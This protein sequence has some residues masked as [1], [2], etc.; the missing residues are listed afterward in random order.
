MLNALKNLVVV[1]AS[2]IPALGIAYAWWGG[3]LKNPLV[4]AALA[5]VYETGVL[6]WAVLGKD[7]WKALQPGLV[8]ATADWTKVTVLNGFSDFRRRYNKHLVF[9]HRVFGSRGLRTQ[10]QGILELEQVFVELQIAPSHALQVSANPLA[11]KSLPGSQPVWEFLRRFKK[12]DATA[13]AI[14]GPPGCGK[15]TLLKHLALTFALNKQRRYR[16]RAYTPL[17]LFL[18]EHAQTIVEHSP[19]L[20]E[21]C[22]AHFSN[23]KRYPELDPPAKWFPRRLKA[24]KCLVLLDG[25]DEVSEERRQEISKWVDRQIREYPCCRFVLT[26]RPQGYLDAPLAQAHVLEVMSFTHE[27]VEDFVRHWYVA[28]KIIQSGKNDP[29]IHRDAERDADDL[30]QRLQKQKNLQELTV[31]PLLLTMIANVHNYR[32]ALP[33]RRVELYMEICDVL[34]GHWQKAKG[35]ED[36]L[37]AKQ[38]RAV[39]QPLAEDMMAE[40]VREMSTQDVL[41][42]MESHLEGV[43]LVKGDAPLFLKNLQEHSGLLLETEAELWG[44]AHLTFQ[45][46]LCAAHWHENSK[47]A[48]WS[49]DEWQVF[50]EDSWWHEML[51][52]YAAQAVDATSLVEACM[53][54]DTAESLK[55]AGNIAKEALKVDPALRENMSKALEERAIIRLRSEPLANPVSDEEFW[56]VFKLDQNQRPLEYIQNDYEDRGELVFDRATGLMWQKS[57]SEPENYANAEKYVQDLNVKRFAGHKDW[58]LPTIPELMSLL[59]PEKQ[60]NDLYINPIFD[61]RQWF[62][63]SCDKRSS[64]S[65]WYV[66]FDGGYVYWYYVKN[67]YYVR[68]VRS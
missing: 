47:P 66:D 51:R 52:L 34:L 33:D 63:W 26:A 29:G 7:V 59:E 38:K 58:R 3:V 67:D 68:V 36:R 56:E 31:N 41:A 2:Q 16:L 8:A 22:E 45:E 44:F 54:A 28:T 57:G 27:Q 60:S 48:H 14:L 21:L 43:G 25:L 10:G 55:L 62:C 65:A 53:R 9:E 6:L 39:L 42:A 35:M 17:L 23:Q 64:G 30:L 15:T 1:L 32:G 49:S 50:I 5:L 37:S 19:S 61:K 40:K 13:L 4:A 11:F 12:N 18:R 46:Y 24:G 20:A